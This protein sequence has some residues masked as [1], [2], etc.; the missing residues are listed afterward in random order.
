MKLYKR[1]ISRCAAG[2]H[3]KAV[4][5]LDIR[6]PFL[7]LRHQTMLTLLREQALFQLACILPKLR[8]LH[9]FALQMLL[10]FQYIL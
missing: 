10:L 2:D 9:D 6:W 7:L 3:I 4:L 5:G 1:F 8:Q